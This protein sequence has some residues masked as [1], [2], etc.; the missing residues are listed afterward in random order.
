MFDKK[1]LYFFVL[2]FFLFLVWW[3]YLHISG[4]VSSEAAYWFNISYG[5]VGLIGGV[6]G[7]I[8]S[9]KWGGIDSLVGKAIIFLSLGLISEW[10]AVTIWSAYNIWLKVEIP[11]PSMADIFYFMIIPFYSIAMFSLA[12]ASG[13]NFTLRLFKNKIVAL[14]VPCISLLLAY[15]FFF[16]D[17]ID[18][19][20]SIKL[21]FDLGYPFGYAIT[22]SIGI[23]T[24][25][26]IK[27]Y[28]GGQMKKIVLSLLVAYFIQFIA[29]Y[30]FLYKAQA[31]TYYNAD[32]VD[33]FYS[34]ALISMSIAVLQFGDFANK[35]NS[36][37]K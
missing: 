35:I 32:W 11:Y 9:K 25:F 36:M 19:S 10:I 3:V 37:K 6:N 20:D 14:I 23:V 17:G 29:D 1:P 7:I 27:N 2:C 33:L 16:R 5:V 13:A 31:G 30:C 26:S 18:T 12:K 21:I 8:I 15:Y 4:L 22:L 28:L 34:I 24:F